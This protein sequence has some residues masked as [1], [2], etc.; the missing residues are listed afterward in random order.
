M[1]TLR[2]IQDIDI[3]G[4]KILADVSR[5]AVG[6]ITRQKFEEVAKQQRGFV[7]LENSQVVGFVLYRHRKLDQQTTLSEICV[8]EDYRGQHIGKQLVNALVQECRKKS[9]QFIQ[10]KCPTDLPANVFYRQLGFELSA[11]EKGKKR[12]LNI[13]RLSLSHQENDKV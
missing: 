13:W 10:L 9:R 1:I 7:A 12:S 4:A 11:T 2:H 3:Q 6:F 8:H 5:D